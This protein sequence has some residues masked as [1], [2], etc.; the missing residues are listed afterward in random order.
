MPPLIWSAA[1]FPLSMPASRP[2]IGRFAPSPSGPLHLGSLYAAVVSW[3]DARAHNGVWLLRME[4][5]DSERC[6]P[7]YAADIR[8]Q[9]ADFGL[10]WDRE[11][12][13]QT[14]R[15]EVYHE[16]LDSWWQRGRIY[17][18]Q[19][20]RKTLAPYRIDGETRYP[21][22]CRPASG[23][24]RPALKATAGMAIR[25]LLPEPSAVEFTDRA[26]GP[27]RQDVARQCG[28]VVIRRRTGD[29][30]YQ[31]V[32]S[33]DD[34]MQGITHVVRGDDLLPSVGRQMLLLQTLGVTPP[35]YL[36]HPLWNDPG[37]AK[38]SKAT[39]AEAISTATRD[40]TLQRVLQALQ[41]SEDV[42]S[43]T[44]PP[45]TE[46]LQQAL[47]LYRNRLGDSSGRMQFSCIAAS[48]G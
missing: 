22:T 6:Q 44:A 5:I 11:V 18:C 10:E 34:A 47:A 7:E 45:I 28:D 33:V 31:F 17:P 20:T 30:T 8:R 13:A 36:H 12:P 46:Q 38:L 35:R 32:V 21:G 40:Y 9:L 37:G 19:C 16:V 23:S 41:L 39:G 15:L 48:H 26:H 2:Y 3:L 25:F 27:L 1:A 24:V 14:Q 29:F 42:T 4:D 43:R